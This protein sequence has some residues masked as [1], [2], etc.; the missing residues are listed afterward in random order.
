[1]S[2]LYRKH[3]FFKNSCKLLISFHQSRYLLPFS[4]VSTVKKPPQIPF[5]VDYL[6]N[7]C[8]FSRYKAISASKSL[9][10]IQSPEN[11]DSV[12]GFLRDCGLSNTQIKHV[13]SWRPK[14]LCANVEKTLVPK[15]WI[16]QEL[17]LSR[18]G[19]AELIMLKPRVLIASV[20]PFIKFLRPLLGSKDDV[21]KTLNRTLWNI[22]DKSI[23]T[24]VQPNISFLKECG[25]SDEMI[26]KLMVRNP[27]FFFQY[28]TRLKDTVN[29]V[30]KLGLTQESGAFIYAIFI[31]GSMSKK[32]VKAKFDLFKSLG[33]SEADAI[34]A[35]VRAPEC[36]KYSE[37]K[38]RASMDYFVKE[39]EYNPSYVVS[40][41][42][43]LTYSLEKRIIP[44]LNILRILKSKE[45]L[46]RSIGLYT[47][48]S[49]SEKRFLERF[50]NPHKE[51]VPEV[52][53]VYTGCM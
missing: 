2:L 31:L 52:L 1:M 18:S 28:P 37:K 19:L 5:L 43:I 46:K 29:L 36:V 33:W 35:F 8:G 17:G 50:L 48:A 6:V 49:M 47:V 3:L 38:I 44:R 16:L 51:S 10:C 7:T 39:L 34:F 26:A 53:K 12:I 27:N 22:T 41:P 42:K 14:L 25:T 4:T 9:N 40:N 11:P 13:V 30:E 32:A 24:L 20:E 21:I 45:L 23:E 15:V